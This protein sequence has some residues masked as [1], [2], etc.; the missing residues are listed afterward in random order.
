MINTQ[1]YVLKIVYAYLGLTGKDKKKP[2]I[3]DV[4]RLLNKFYRKV[5]IR[6]KK[7]S[8]C[9]LSELS[10]IKTLNSIAKHI[11]EIN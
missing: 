6:I 5:Y 3:E 10:L 2:Q 8:L 4:G 7:H 11:I 9:Y 1:L